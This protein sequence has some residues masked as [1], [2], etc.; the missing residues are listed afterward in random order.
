MSNLTTPEAF[1]IIVELIKL[2]V[3][4]AIWYVTSELKAL[5]KSNR[6]LKDSFKES[7][8]HLKN[9]TQK[10]ETILIGADGK[11]GLRSRIRRL[12]IKVDQLTIAQAARHGEPPIF[13]TVV[14]EDLD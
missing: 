13:R 14:E 9:D 4:P 10:V 7:M 11:N 2:A 3:L 8:D 6:D 5:H 12:E 1:Q